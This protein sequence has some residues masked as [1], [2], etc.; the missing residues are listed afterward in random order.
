MRLLWEGRACRIFDY[1]EGRVLRRYK[2]DGTPYVEAEFMRIA[3]A[4]GV[5]CPEVFEVLPDGLVLERVD[6]Q[7]MH[8]TLS[9]NP[10]R[11]ALTSA[12]S[13]LTALHDRLHAITR[14][15]AALIHRDLHWKNII[16]SEAGLVL[17]DWSNA[18][19]GDAD[20]DTAL[21]WVILTTS[22]G[23]I[24]RLLAEQFARVAD[25]QTARRDAAIYRLKDASLTDPERRALKGILT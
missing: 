17:V 1:G 5:I 6:G 25:T 16:E 18:T 20:F 7:T 11:Q 3:H 9:R 14:D 8:Q 2:R 13:Q 19:W 24:G 12:A 21:T 10:S 23:E 4:R 15:G 22:S